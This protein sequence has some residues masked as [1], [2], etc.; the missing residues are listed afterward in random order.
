MSKDKEKYIVKYSHFGEVIQGIFRNISKNKC[1]LSLPISIDNKKNNKYIKK[2]YYKDN[3]FFSKANCYSK[4]KISKKLVLKPSNYQKS[5][6]LLKKISDLNPKKKIYGE[7]SIHSSIPECRGLG[8]S[9]STLV[10]LI[11]LLK[12]KF[13][14]N[15]SNTEA[16]KICASIEPTDPILIKKNYLFS[17]KEG[18]KKKFFKFKFPKL[19]IYGFDTDPNGKGVNTVKMKDIKYSKVELDFFKKAYNNLQKIKTYDK[20]IFNNISRKSLIINQKYFPKNKLKKILQLESKLSNEFIVGAHSG[21]V[22]GFVYRYDKISGIKFKENNDA[23]IIEMIS[24]ILKLK[25]TKYLY[26]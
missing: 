16:L 6:L 7:I 4:Y 21:T 1:A 2:N 11:S 19:I 10:S 13:K 25:I 18:I 17:T 5:K 23:K 8:S 22:M 24:K 14:I 12:K 9:T 3:F 26:V 15:L 20:K